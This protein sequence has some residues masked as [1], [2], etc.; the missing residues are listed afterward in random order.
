MSKTKIYLLGILTLVAFPLIALLALYFFA[1]KSPLEILQLNR[2]FHP[3]SILGIIWGVV[4]AYI[5]MR[6]FSS[7]SFDVEMK[8]QR[9]MILSLK[10]N[11]LDKVF[12]SFCAGFGE[13]ILFRSGMQYWCGIWITSIFFIAIHGYLNPKKPKLAI[14]GLFLI[15][16]IV[17]LGYA[18]GTLGLWFCIFTHAAYDLVLFASMKEEEEQVFF[19]KRLL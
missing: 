12:L 5:S 3:Y 15:P 17:S 2:V 13:E 10:L 4:F 18:L 9:N 16:F 14:Y 7:P 11:F 6:M 8:Q 19:K 1:H